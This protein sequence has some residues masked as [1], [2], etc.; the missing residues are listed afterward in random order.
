MAQRKSV[1]RVRRVY[2]RARSSLARR[3]RSSGRGGV[4]GGL[5]GTVLSGVIGGVSAQVGNRFLGA[6][7]TAVGY[8]AAGY[9]TGN[10]VL[11][12]M[13]GISASSMLPVG[14]LLGGSGGTGNGGAI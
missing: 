5:L 4:F 14:S 1:A 10:H 12:T 8:G 2:R 7:G 6:P 13:A 3:A 11:L 9:I